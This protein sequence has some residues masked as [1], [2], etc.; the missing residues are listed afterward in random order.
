LILLFVWILLCVIDALGGLLGWLE[1]RRED[2]RVARYL[3]H[4]LLASG[5]RSGITIV[6]LVVFGLNVK[7][8][9]WYLVLGVSAVAY[10]AYAT[11]GWLLYARNVING[12]GWRDLF[13]RKRARG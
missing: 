11:W 4:I 5:Y 12:G 13:R 3:A 7:A 10:K 9:L 8:Q 6:G 1:L 2:E